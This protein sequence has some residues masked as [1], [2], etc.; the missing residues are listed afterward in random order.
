M[1]E[2]VSVKGIPSVTYVRILPSVADA[3]TNTAS[4]D[5]LS[6][7]NSIMVVEPGQPS[8]RYDVAQVIFFLNKMLTK[9]KL[10]PL[11]C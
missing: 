2:K 10:F 11:H 6:E 3:A 9:R 5:V 4:A 8:I 1:E 7:G